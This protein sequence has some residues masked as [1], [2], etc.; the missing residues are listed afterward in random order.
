[1]VKPGIDNLFFMGL[2]QP[3]PTLVNFP[4]QQS[5]LVAALLSGRYALPSKQDMQAAIAADERKYL[6][7]FY[8]SPRHTIQVDFSHYVDDLLKEMRRG[9][10]RARR[11][12]SIA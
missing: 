9:E 3:L 11:H 1:M 7:H 8:D 4:E 2:A 6:G 12:R 10:Q 5:K